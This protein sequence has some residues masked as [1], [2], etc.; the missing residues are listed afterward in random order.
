M[1]D[2]IGDPLPGMIGSKVQING[3]VYEVVDTIDPG[4]ESRVTPEVKEVL[5]AMNKQ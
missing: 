2:S 1:S 3:K 5:D 4:N